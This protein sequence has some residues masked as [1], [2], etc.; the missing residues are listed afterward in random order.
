MGHIWLRHEGGGEG[1]QNW[2]EL[3]QVEQVAVIDAS[4]DAW[5]ENLLICYG[6]F[7]N[8]NILLGII[9]KSSIKYAV[10]HES[11]WKSSSYWLLWSDETI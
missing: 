7:K 1:G 9:K 6:K 10:L 2:A 11:I 5:A 3:I 8:A 4:H